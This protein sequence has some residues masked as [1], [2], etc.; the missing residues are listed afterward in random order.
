MKNVKLV[1]F[2]VIVILLGTIVLM[3][4]DDKGIKNGLLNTLT[5]NKE[6]I[7]VSKIIN[8]DVVGGVLS[9][10]VEEGEVVPTSKVVLDAKDAD[11]NEEGN[12]TGDELVYEKP[13]R[14]A[15]KVKLV[16]NSTSWC[17]DKPCLIG[18]TPSMIGRYEDGTRVKISGEKEEEVV[19]V[20]VLKVVD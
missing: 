14:P 15:I 9:E 8:P 4:F 1:G 19:K 17:E 2:S 13:G 20:Y 7:K 18:A 10:P 6:E 5:D 12:L 16:F 11:F 3:I